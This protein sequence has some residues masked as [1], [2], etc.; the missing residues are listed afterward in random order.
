MLRMDNSIGWESWTTIIWLQAVRTFEKQIASLNFLIEINFNLNKFIFRASKK[1]HYSMENLSKT[2]ISS[3]SSTST[4]TSPASSFM[5]SR[6]C[7]S[8]Y[9]SQKPKINPK[10]PVVDNTSRIL[11]RAQNTHSNKNGINTKKEPTTQR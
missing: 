2:R 10:L 9:R 3:T 6:S 1:L 8:I 7:D 4:S 11:E 5:S